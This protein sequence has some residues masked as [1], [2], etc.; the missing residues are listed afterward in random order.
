[1]TAEL[2][3]FRSGYLAAFRSYLAGGGET[4]LESAYELGREAVAGELSLLELAGI[5]HDVLAE[6]LASAPKGELDRVA[7]AGTEFFRE[8]LSTFEMIQRGFGEA[9]ET[10]R[11]EQRHAAQLRGLA[12]AALALNSTLS[13]DEMLALL[14]ERACEIVGADRS[15]VSMVADGGDGPRTPLLE[16]GRLIAP[17]IDRDEHVLGLIELSGKREGEFTDED[18]SIVVQLAHMASVAMENARLY[19]RERGIALELQSTLLPE[20]LPEIPGV[21]T[22]SRYRA[23]GDGVRVGGDWYEVVTLGGGRVGMAIG[24][25]VGRGV[26]A[27]AMMGHLRMALRAYALE[28]EAPAIVAERMARFVRT[29]DRDQMSTCVYAVLEP[30][31]GVLRCANAGHPPPLVLAGDGRASFLTGRPGLPLGVTADYEYPELRATL[32]PGST[33]LLYTD[34]L[35]EKRGEPLDVGLERLR[36]VAAGAPV[37]PLEELC[38]RVLEVLVQEAPGDDVALLAVRVLPPEAGPLDLALPAEP[39]ALVTLRRRLGAWLAH[40][41]AGKSETYDIV[42][43]TCEA[44]A[45][46]VEHAYGPGEAKFRVM[47]RAEEGEVTVEVRDNGAWRD[48]RDPRRGR[49]LAVMRELMDDVS[50][51]SDDEGTN[52]R[53]R[54]RLGEG[55]QRGPAGA[56]RD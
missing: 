25:V 47:A 52:V 28:G 46:A 27:A 3:A 55:R 43:A 40:A 33:V 8:S 1:M 10:A 30:A 19:E 18:E 35:V 38:E 36:E 2:D 7:R 50:V 51:N 53:L 44:S 16:G 41:G 12:D 6:C 48:Q 17:L 15:A 29:L 45:N 11:L 39:G 26:R 49:G 20:D 23:G 32:E 13:V 37:E 4:G 31:T 24:D 34:G 21:A 14:G 42:L 56:D 9:Q 5:H 54:R 22:A